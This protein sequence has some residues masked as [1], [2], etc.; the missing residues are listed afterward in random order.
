MFFLINKLVI[1]HR[2]KTM[3]RNLVFYL[4]KVVFHT[5]QGSFTNPPRFVHEPSKVCSRTL[6][7]SFCHLL[8]LSE[9][10]FDGRIFISNYYK[11][12]ETQCFSLS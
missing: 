12:R 7:G 1:F 6:Q 5:F 11:K 4:K 2:S 10:L 8:G 3:F 9:R